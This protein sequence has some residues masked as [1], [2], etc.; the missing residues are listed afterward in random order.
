MSAISVTAVE[1]SFWRPKDDNAP[2]TQHQA[3]ITMFSRVGDRFL[4]PF[5]FISC[6]LVP[7]IIVAI[8][9][10]IRIIIIIPRAKNYRK[11]NLRIANEPLQQLHVSL[12]PYSAAICTAVIPASSCCPGSTYRG[13]CS[14]FHISSSSLAC[15]GGG[16]PMRWRQIP[17][18][19]GRS[20]Q[21]EDECRHYSY[22]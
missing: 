11:V 9:I 7:I 6:L 14:Y 8:I 20:R 12:C 3:Q 16:K 10:I 18:G 2:Q 19:S 4:W 17:A 1:R 22:M 15:T 21:V 5:F 13:M